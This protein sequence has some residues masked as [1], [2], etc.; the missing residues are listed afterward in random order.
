LGEHAWYSLGE[1]RWYIIVRMVTQRDVD[2]VDACAETQHPIA[3]YG[4]WH[5]RD[6]WVVP[7]RNPAYELG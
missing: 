3:P 7:G 2:W 1:Y 5:P 4:L 6:Y